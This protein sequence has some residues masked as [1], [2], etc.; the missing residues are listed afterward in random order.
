[1]V[2]SSFTLIL[3]LLS[4]FDV[5]LSMDKT[6]NKACMERE[7]TCEDLRLKER[8][9]VLMWNKIPIMGQVNVDIV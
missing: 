9:G 1:M 4:G 6:K 7:L 2:A 3:T 8:R 5:V